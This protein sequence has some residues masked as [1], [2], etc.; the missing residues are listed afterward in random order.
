VYARPLPPPSPR[1]LSRSLAT[2][3]ERYPHLGPFKSYIAFRYAPP[4]THDA[5][6]AMA[7]D[8]VTRAVAFAQYPQFSCTT[9]GSSLNHLWR[10]AIRLGLE[11]RFA[12]SVLDRWHSHPGFLA[13]VARRVALGLAQ[14]EPAVR[15]KVVILFS[16]HSVPMMTVNRGDAYVTEVAASVSGVMELVRRGVDIGDGRSDGGVAGAAAAGSAPPPAGSS[17]VISGA[18]NPHTLSWQSKVGFLPWMGPST[19]SA[20]KGLGAQGHQH[21]LAVPIAFTSDHVETLY[22]IDLEYA[23]EAAAAGIAQWRR[24]PSLNDEPLLTD[25]MAELVAGHVASGHAAASP[26]YALNCP[27]CVNPACRTVLNPVEPY[28]KLREGNARCS[29][30]GWPGAADVAAL[31]ARGAAPCD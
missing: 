8:G 19:A 21:V 15:H 17:S 1:A 29:V 24:A 12:W 11:R 18:R 25:A 31:R 22:E 2:L 23:V 26:A 28:A 7:A 13:A 6:Q 4:L 27:G 10:E 3:Q 5:L 30:Q 14:F 20:I 9:T 16:A